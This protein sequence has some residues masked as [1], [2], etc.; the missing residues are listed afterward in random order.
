MGWFI[1]VVMLIPGIWEEV[2]FRGVMLPMLSK[3][4]SSKIAILISSVIFGLVHS[5][6]IIITI[7]YGANPILILF[8]VIYATFLGISFAY[9]YVKTGSLLPSIITHYLI[10]AVG[11]IFFNV[12]IND[13]FLAG[14]FLIGFIGII[15]SVLM[16][17]LVKFFMQRENRVKKF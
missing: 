3:K 7:I 11:Q 6:N 15:P 14:L 16:I 2:A 10:D 12:Q 9:M 17:L 13:I 1:F 5:F 4:Y 8:Q